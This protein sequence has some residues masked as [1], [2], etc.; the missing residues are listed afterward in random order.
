[1]EK[2]VSGATKYKIVSPA[3]WLLKLLRSQKACWGSLVT[4]RA[5]AAQFTSSRAEALHY[6]N[7]KANQ[8]SE[9]KKPTKEQKLELNQN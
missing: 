3:A 2:K 7:K 6:G 4:S 8:Q 1:V 9:N 5:T